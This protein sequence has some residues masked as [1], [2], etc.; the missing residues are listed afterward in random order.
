MYYSFYRNRDSAFVSSHFAPSFVDFL[1]TV[2]MNEVAWSG[3]VKS[4][5]GYHVVYLKDRKKAFY[6]N[7]VDIKSRVADDFKRAKRRQRKM[8]LYQKL[9]DSYNVKIK[10]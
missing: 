10:I 9:I 1:K 2:D 4:P 5:Y 8:A 3:P 6:P 7:W